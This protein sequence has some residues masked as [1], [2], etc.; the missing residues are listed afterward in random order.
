V[1]KIIVSKLSG[2]IG[3]QLFQFAASYAL[4]KR[5]RAALFF[6]DSWYSSHSHGHH[7]KLDDIFNIS[8]LRCPLVKQVNAFGVYSFPPLRR[9]LLSSKLKPVRPKC[10]YAEPHYHYSSELLRSRISMFVYGLWQSESYFS[11]YKHE[12]RSIIR[13]KYDLSRNS[14]EV[15]NHIL[16]SNSISVHVRRGDYF[17][18]K[19][20]I[21]VHGVCL[22]EYYS[23]SIE[24]INNHFKDPVFFIFSDDPQWA[25]ENIEVGGKSFFVSCNTGPQSYQ[26]MHLMS[27]CR[28]NIIAN[29]TFS[30]WA[31]WLN[32]NTNKVIIAPSKWFNNSRI[33]SSDVC[34]TNWLRF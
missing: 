6:D 23:R 2:G 3:N 22:R 33:D 26:D 28:H 10:L 7:P 17:A 5:S 25:R 31:A 29:S 11:D 15:S 20:S 30:W 19:D 34:P 27:L 12:L 8:I 14:R 1:K 9:L 13:F 32:S 16:Q 18:S 4:A 24:Y 21:A